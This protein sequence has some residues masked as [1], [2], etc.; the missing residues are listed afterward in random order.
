MDKII[1]TAS[2]KAEA[3]KIIENAVVCYFE[4][5]DKEMSSQEGVQFITDIGLVGQDELINS[6]E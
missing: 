1:A 6:V 5:L 4:T 2:K 3:V